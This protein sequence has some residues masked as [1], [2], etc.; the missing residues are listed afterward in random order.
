MKNEQPL[1]AR[2]VERLR[3]AFEA[4]RADEAAGIRV[5]LL[6]AW[7]GLPPPRHVRVHA[8]YQ[9]WRRVGEPALAEAASRVLADALASG[10]GRVEVRVPPHAYAHLSPAPSG[11]IHARAAVA[12]AGSAPGERTSLR[13]AM[14]EGEPLLELQRLA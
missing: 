13:P 3:T 4:R 12:R 1:D 7:S 10:A 8:L 2:T 5:P 6:D 9:R 11:A 14:A